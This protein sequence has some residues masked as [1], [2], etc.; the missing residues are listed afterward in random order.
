MRRNTQAT[1]LFLLSGLLLG[2]CGGG[3]AAPGGNDPLEKATLT[4]EILSIDGQST[5]LDGVLVSLVET[6]AV[7]VTDADGYFAFP[8]VPTGTLT[9][10][11]VSPLALG[12]KAG[13]GG[14]G[15]QGDSGASGGTGGSGGPHGDA[16]GDGL[17]D[18]DGHMYHNGECFDDDAIDDGE[19]AGDDSVSVHRV[20][21]QERVHLRI[22]LQDGA[23]Q[24][25]QCT[26]AEN[27]ERETER[28]MECVADGGAECP[29]EGTME[30][31]RVHTRERE[32]ERF[33]VCVDGA[34]PGRELELWVFSGEG[35]GECLGTQTANANGE[36]QWEAETGSG[37]GLPHGADR[38]ED[39]EGY[40]VRVCAMNGEP[41]LE[42]DAPP[43]AQGQPAQALP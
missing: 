29:L 33:R 15:G 41:M 25:M 11:L 5:S 1:L 21:E 6:G 27:Q 42:G 16:N 43:L 34:E 38:I 17:C 20:R 28:H 3:A 7:A 39:M 24:E 2:G 13:A 4:G 12:M 10:D 31:E 14:M 19:D 35:V 37:P 40:R 9:V 8:S 32:R 30:M 36:C 22:R 26:R 23:I 18:E